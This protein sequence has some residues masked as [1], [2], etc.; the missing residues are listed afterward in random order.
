MTDEERRERRRQAKKRYRVRHR[1]KCIAYGKAYRAARKK[2]PAPRPTS[3]T[4]PTCLVDKPLHAF[5]PRKKITGQRPSRGAHGVNRLCRQCRSHLRK[6]SL[7]NERRKH[8]EMQAAHI[9]TC[10]VCWVTKPFE[11]FNIRRASTDGRS[12]T[13][14]ACANARTSRWKKN[15]PTAHAEWYQENRQ[16]KREYWA[17]WRAANAERARNTYRQWAAAHRGIVNANVV[18]RD[19]SKRHATPRWA[20]RLM[21]RAFYLEAARLT[22]ETG[23]RHEVDHIVPIRSRLVCGLH[24]PA[25]LQILTREANQKKGNHLHVVPYSP[26]ST[27]LR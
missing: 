17:K 14:R 12:H 20:D 6:P 2:P 7:I 4:C 11:Q 15:H 21:M 5:S 9:K 1:D 10:N 27:A 26:P 25:N 22:R 16:H 3:K 8:A 13:C 18:R 19:L 23:I 24:V